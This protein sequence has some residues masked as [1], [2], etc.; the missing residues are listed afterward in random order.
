MCRFCEEPSLKGSGPR[1]MLCK[2]LSREACWTVHDN[3][4]SASH[5]LPLG[6]IDTVARRGRCVAAAAAII[7]PS[8]VVL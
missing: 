3:V 5:L 8:V 6:V 2:S 4:E 7:N 1:D